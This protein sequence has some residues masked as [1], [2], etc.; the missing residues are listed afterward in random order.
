M[1]RRPSCPCRDAHDNNVTAPENA[2]F[3]RTFQH[4]ESAQRW[5]RHI[6][7]QVQNGWNGVA[8]LEPAPCYFMSPVRFRTAQIPKGERAASECSL[9]PR[10]PRQLQLLGRGIRAG[11]IGPA[12]EARE[13]QRTF[14]VPPSVLSLEADD[15]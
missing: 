4:T 2:P 9:Q 10:L 8:V 5:Q 15:L 12:R 7:L 6:P 3:E 1:K 11:A 14:S 13:C